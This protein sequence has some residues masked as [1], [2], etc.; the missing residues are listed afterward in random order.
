M[1]EA[2]GTSG[3]V[4]CIG[5]KV[6]RRQAGRFNHQLA[7]ALAIG[8][9]HLLGAADQLAIHHVLLQVKVKALQASAGKAVDAE[10]GGV[11]LVELNRLGLVIESGRGNTEVNRGV[12]DPHKLKLQLGDVV[13][14]GRHLEGATAT[15]RQVLLAVSVKRQRHAGDA[16]VVG[17]RVISDRRVSHHRLGHAGGFKQTTILWSAACSS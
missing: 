1:G 17:E 3:A 2:D 11:A 4:G 14:L 15:G 12:V 10:V 9:A 5:K 8:D 13:D 6:M 16:A 7:F